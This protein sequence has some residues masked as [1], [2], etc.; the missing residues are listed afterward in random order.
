MSIIFLGHY[1]FR[2]PEE[3]TWFIQSLC[4]EVNKHDLTSIDFL[5]IM[6]RVSRRVAL[7]NESYSPEIPWLHQQKQIPSIHS[8]LIRDLFFKPKK[9]P[10]P[11]PIIITE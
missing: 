1:S 7:D 9:K 8:M 6:T 5:R 10:A 4:A 2:S 3:G 11:E